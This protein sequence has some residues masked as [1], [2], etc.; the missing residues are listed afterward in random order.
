ML[1]SNLTLSLAN[2]SAQNLLKKLGT[3]SVINSLGRSQSIK[4]KRLKNACAHYSADQ[5]SIPLIKVTRFKNLYVT[6]MIALKPYFV[7]EKAS[8]KS[9][10]S[11]KKSINGDLIGCKDL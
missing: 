10:V 6:D 8:I 5:V 3:Q 11:V 4:F 7:S 2:N 9:S 1:Y